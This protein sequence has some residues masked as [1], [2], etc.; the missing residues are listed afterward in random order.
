MKFLWPPWHPTVVS[1]RHLVDRGRV[2]AAVGSAVAVVVLGCQAEVS[3]GMAATGAIALMRLAVSEAAPAP[4][5]SA[6]P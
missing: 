3:D 4:A 6:F 1:H 5:W 2:G